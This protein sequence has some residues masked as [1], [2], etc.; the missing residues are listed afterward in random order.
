MRRLTVVIIII[1]VVIAIRRDDIDSA[2]YNCARHANSGA[3]NRAGR[4]HSGADDCAD[5]A[6]QQRDAQQSRKDA[7]HITPHE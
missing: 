7:D 5:T 3:D 2:A 4:T 6:R 1:I